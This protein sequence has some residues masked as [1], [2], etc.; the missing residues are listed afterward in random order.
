MSASYAAPSKA[1][2]LFDHQ[3]SKSGG[4]KPKGGNDGPSHSGDEGSVGGH[5]GVPGSVSGVDPSFILIAGNYA[6]RPSYRPQG[7][8][9]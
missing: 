7:K 2:G 1:M 5:K 3:W 6:M 8:T 9:E 4:G